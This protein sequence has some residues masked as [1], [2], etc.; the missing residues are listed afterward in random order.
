MCVIDVTHFNNIVCLFVCLFVFSSNKMY[1]IEMTETSPL[2]W[3]FI[4]FL[5][6]LNY[7]RIV[8]HFNC[9]DDHDDD[10][11]RRLAGD[12]AAELVVSQHCAEF[13]TTYF[14]ICG[15]VLTVFGAVVS[16]STWKSKAMLM[17]VAA[18][19]DYSDFT[20]ILNEI[21]DKERADSSQILRR[22]KSGADDDIFESPRSTDHRSDAEWHV[23]SLRQV[24]GEHKTKKAEEKLKNK[25]EMIKRLDKYG[26]YAK[27]I[28]FVGGPQIHD[29]DF[30]KMEELRAKRK[31]YHEV[32]SKLPRSESGNYNEN[33]ERANKTLRRASMSS[34]LTRRASSSGSVEKPSVFL[35]NASMK[36]S[37]A[38]SLGNLEL[39]EDKGA[40]ENEDNEIH[41]LMFELDEI[42]IF[43]S[44]FLFKKMV[45]LFQILNSLFIA[46]WLTNFVF[47]ALESRRPMLYTG[48][49][50]VAI[51]LMLYMLSFIQLHATCVLALTSLQNDATEWICEQDIMKS[52]VLPRLGN[53]LFKL[54]DEKKFDYEI[55]MIFNLVKDLNRNGISLK[56]FHNLLQTLNLYLSKDEVNC[57]FRVMDTDGSGYI[58]LCEV[59]ELMRPNSSYV[60]KSK[61]SPDVISPS[62][63]PVDMKKEREK[64]ISGTLHVARL[65]SQMV[66]K[67]FFDDDDDNDSSDNV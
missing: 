26:L 2:S 46:L 10:D 19:E 34:P 11:H 6:V 5:V 30:N 8:L 39:A 43:Q 32:N 62:L 60:S 58:E 64:R 25:Q 65:E 53:E 12:D 52:E 20:H 51:V 21:I 24:I 44:R 7:I 61:E 40:N 55:E 27:C 47:I 15:A 9:Q 29:I 13:T 35:R 14:L 18:G 17:T 28:A 38:L 41:P 67:D 45:E 42:F 4:C 33:S 37:R 54:L 63:E 23:V 57:L 56:Q 66:S 36:M 48:L 49:I 1:A 3:L 31:L 16:Y 22:E 50:I 59:K